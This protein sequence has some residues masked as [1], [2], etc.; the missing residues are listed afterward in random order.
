MSVSITEPAVP[1]PHHPKSGRSRRTEP[2]TNRVRRDGKF[3]RLGADKFFV[4]GVTYGPFAPN[5]RGENLPETEQVERDF[6]HI[7]SI[8]CNCIRVYHLPPTWLLDL[9]DSMEMKVFVDVPWPK[10]VTFLQDQAAEDAARAA[11]RD[12][13]R[14][15]G[16]HPATFAISVVNEIPAEI[17]RFMGHRAV[18]SFIDDLIDIVHDE[19]PDCLATFA[20]YPSTEFLYPHGTDFI[21]FNV[22]LHDD[23]VLRNYLGRLQSIAQDKPLMLGEYGIDTMKER[24]EEKQAE[25]LELHIRAVFEEGLVGTFIFSY[26]DD[27]FTG[28]YQID[29]WAF[30]ITRADRSPKPACEALQRIFA[31]VPQTS[32]EVLPMISVI[33]CSYNGSSTVESCLRSMQRIKYENFE[34]VFVDDGSTDNTQTILKDFEN[35]PRLRVI[36]QKNKGLSFARNVGM[37]AALGEII[38]YTDSDCEADE[39]WLYYIALAMVRSKHVGMGGPNLIPDEGSWVASCVGLSPGGPTHVMIDDRTA[40]HVPGCNMAFYTWAAKEIGGFDPQFRTAGDDVDFIWRLQNRGYSIGFSPA[41]QVWHYRRNTIAAYLKQQRGYGV[42]EALLKYKHPDKFNA[43]GASHWKGKI[44]GGNIGVH[45]GRDVIYHGVFGTGLFQTIYRQPASL[46]AAMLMSIEWHWLTLFTAVLG[47]AFIPS[48][49]FDQ[50][51][52]WAGVVFLVLTKDALLFSAMVMFA[53]PVTLAMMAAIQSPMPRRRHPLARLL[54]AWLHFRQPI[55]RGWARYSVM[56]KA[57]VLGTRVEKL[58]PPADLPVDPHDRS[59]LRYWHEYEPG[60]WADRMTLLEHICSEVGPLGWRIRVDS[61]WSPWDLELYLS[62]YLKVRILTASELH[63]KGVLTRVKVDIAMSTFTKLL[64]LSSSLLMIL[65][66]AYVWPFSRPA[67]LLPF[68]LWMIY[69]AS[70]ARV[71]RPVM[72]V[73]HRAAQRN[74]L[75]SIPTSTRSSIA[76]GNTAPTSPQAA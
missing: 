44:Y 69:L 52:S 75:A 64:V 42:A 36:T 30:G 73:V 26:T 54:I 74:G 27:W 1:E 38:L 58:E 41:A 25:I 50:G 14:A 47:L 19:A 53:I 46:V 76:A 60:K 11:V 18:E 3:F 45:I 31:R 2:A 16:N 65:L 35:W 8:G 68:L 43:L 28:G 59:V 71:S 37:N 29:N 10:Y 6:A 5:S 23:T 22:Y 49:A 48:E 61:G 55:V 33:V 4:K 66:L 56:L 24:T 9:A 20:N 32:D 67:V 12:A 21:C 70:M 15:C 13:A 51:R 39:Q 40:E 7:R 63:A 72:A 62:R 57:R 17:V 34:V